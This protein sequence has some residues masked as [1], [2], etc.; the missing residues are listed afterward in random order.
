V[1]IEDDVS[2][3]DCLIMDHVILKK[4]CTL[5]RVIVDKHNV[6]E[7]GVEIGF[8]PDKD[9]FRCHIDTSGIAIIPRGGRLIKGSK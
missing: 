7:E 5:K 3:E 8:T 1:T 9:R 2:V 4:G 6:I